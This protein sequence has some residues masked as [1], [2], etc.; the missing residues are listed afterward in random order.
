M[1]HTLT[2]QWYINYSKMTLVVF[3]PQ[4]ALWWFVQ[5]YRLCKIVIGPVLQIYTHKSLSENSTYLLP[6][7]CNAFKMCKTKKAKTQNSAQYPY[8]HKFT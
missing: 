1:Q 2:F 8:F 4:I 7:L 6:A 3:R 5:H